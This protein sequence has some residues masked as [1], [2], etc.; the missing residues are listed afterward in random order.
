VTL[1]QVLVSGTALKKVGGDGVKR[2]GLHV[3]YLGKYK[4]RG[5][6]NTPTPVYQASAPLIPR[7]PLCHTSLLLHLV[8]ALI[9]LHTAVRMRTGFSVS[10]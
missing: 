4:F 7:P 8:A 6:E 1:V 10:E 2:L 5:M 3:V 9:A